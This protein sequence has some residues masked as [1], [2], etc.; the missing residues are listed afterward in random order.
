M[1]KEH[2]EA[3]AFRPPR[4]SRNERRRDYVEPP[5][6]LDSLGNESWSHGDYDDGPMSS[7]VSDDGDGWGR[8]DDDEVGASADHHG[9][10]GSLAWY[11]T[12][13]AEPAEEEQSCEALDPK[14]VDEQIEELND[15]IDGGGGGGGEK[16]NIDNA[17]GE[18]GGGMAGNFEEDG[19]GIDVGGSGKEV[20]DEGIGNHGGGNGNGKGDGA[21]DGDGDANAA[22]VSA[23][24]A[25]ACAR[26]ANIEEVMRG[27]SSDNGNGGNAAQALVLSFP[28]CPSP[29]RSPTRKSTTAVAASSVSPAGRNH[30]DLHLFPRNHGHPRNNGA[31]VMVTTTVQERRSVVRGSVSKQSQRQHRQQHMQGR[32][33]HSRHYHH[34][35][36][37]MY[38]ANLAVTSAGLCAE[39]D[40]TMAGLHARLTIP[41]SVLSA[42]FFAYDMFSWICTSIALVSQLYRC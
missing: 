9:R 39:L 4:R 7:M 30:S 13:N 10:W 24:V 3:H 42:S 33:R 31:S 8:D 12:G 11:R 17:S 37:H 25:A 19:A 1:R 38:H 34:Q 14:T 23:L 27:E 36:R 28:R 5:D 40:A 41:V 26:A 20:N 22:A 2:F 35:E 6:S 32:S 21:D 15:T 16:A 18:V 29:L